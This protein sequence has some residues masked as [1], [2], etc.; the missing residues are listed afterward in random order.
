MGGDRAADYV[1]TVAPELESGIPQGMRKL[2]ATIE[3]AA[4]GSALGRWLCLF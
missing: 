3:Q 1:S 4:L 2:A